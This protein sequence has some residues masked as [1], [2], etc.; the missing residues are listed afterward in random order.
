MILCTLDIKKIINQR[1]IYIIA[2]LLCILFSI[3]YE[4]FSHGVISNF[5]ILAFL[6]PLLL[7]VVGTYIMF[8]LKRNKLPTLFENHLSNAGVAT[9][10]FGSIMEG[11]L[12]IYGTTN[13][14]IYLYLI[15]GLILIISSILLYSFRKEK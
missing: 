2:T 3:I 12:E 4:S 11:V 10:T 13:V 7:G 15:V 5:M 1:L 14:K 9:L 8:F 6:I